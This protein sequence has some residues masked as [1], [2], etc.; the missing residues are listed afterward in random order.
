MHSARRGTPHHCSVP[1]RSLR[2]P[3]RETLCCLQWPPAST[4]DSDAP[5]RTRRRLAPTRTTTA[6]PS[7]APWNPSLCLLTAAHETTMVSHCKAP[8]ADARTRGTACNPQGLLI[9]GELLVSAWA[10]RPRCR[11]GPAQPCRHRERRRR[12]G[13]NPAATTP[14]GGPGRTRTESRAGGL[15][16]RMAASDAGWRGCPG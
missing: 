12:T 1:A 9:A 10:P 2:E 7:P 15:S 14:C 11:S 16:A 6:R 8:A 3:S 5:T 4:T 13:Q